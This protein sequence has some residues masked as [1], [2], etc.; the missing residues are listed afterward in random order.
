MTDVKGIDKAALLAVCVDIGMYYGPAIVAMASRNCEQMTLE[1][2]R[3]ILT[4]STYFDRLNGV[5]LSLNME[6]DT[7]SGYVFDREFGAG[8]FEAIVAALRTVPDHGTDEGFVKAHC[9][10]MNA[11]RGVPRQQRPE[12][13]V[14]Q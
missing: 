13:C 8:T 6:G 2:A 10:A 1:R 9:A 7:I 14:L 5:K 3:A 12:E 4:E 11:A